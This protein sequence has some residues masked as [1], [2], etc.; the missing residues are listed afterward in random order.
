MKNFWHITAKTISYL[1]IPPMMI[2]YSYLFI[3]FKLEEIEAF[4]LYIPL[5]FG[6]VLPILVFILLRKKGLVTDNEAMNKEE[7]NFP[8]MIGVGILLAGGVL[9]YLNNISGVPFLFLVSYFF[10]SL[11]I[12]PITKYW[13]I[14]AHSMGTAVPGALLYIYGGPLF[15]ITLALT[16]AV[17]WSRIYLR[18]HDIYQLS[19]GYLLGFTI[20]YLVMS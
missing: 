9:F 12:I 8:Y 10:C 4:Q 11:I 15:Y 5:I 16:A 20:S 14:S 6:T 18:C 2:L 17:W 7:R 3:Y 13:K 1:F 19:A